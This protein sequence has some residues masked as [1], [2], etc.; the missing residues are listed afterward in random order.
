MP[1]IALAGVTE[2]GPTAEL[3]EVFVLTGSIVEHAGTDQA[4]GEPAAVLRDLTQSIF[5]DWWQRWERP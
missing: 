3:R 5:H 1:T 2:A 4:L